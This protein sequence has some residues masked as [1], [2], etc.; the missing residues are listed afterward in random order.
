MPSVSCPVCGRDVFIARSSLR[1]HRFHQ[2]SCRRLWVAI[3]YQRRC[4]SLVHLV[5]TSKKPE[6]GL[7]CA[8]RKCC[9]L[10]FPLWLSSLGN[11]GADSRFVCNVA[12][13]PASGPNRQGPVNGLRRP[14]DDASRWPTDI[15]P[16]I[17]ANMEVIYADLDGISANLQTVSATR[18]RGSSHP[19]RYL[20]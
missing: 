11:R 15:R 5:A 18:Y 6:T 1:G 9:T 10:P 8:P 14:Q 12:Q 13:S 4:R 2:Y 17:C 3:P 19:A 16:G 7:F 20:R